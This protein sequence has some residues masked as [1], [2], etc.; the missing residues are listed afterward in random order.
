MYDVKNILELEAE[1][2]NILLKRATVRLILDSKKTLE[3]GDDTN[4]LDNADTV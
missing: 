3:Q 2:L 4:S 1:Q